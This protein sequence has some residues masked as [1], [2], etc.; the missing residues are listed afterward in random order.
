[1]N[2]RRFTPTPRIISRGPGSANCAEAAQGGQRSLRAIAAELAQ[3][4]IL[5]ERGRS[6]SAA[7]I[8]PMLV[9]GDPQ[10]H[11][12]CARQPA[13]RGRCSDAGDGAT[14]GHRYGGGIL[15]GRWVTLA[16]RNAARVR[17]AWAGGD[18]VSTRP[19]QRADCS[20]DRRNDLAGNA[21]PR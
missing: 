7:V 14:Q 20:K 1:M 4:G 21:K 5:N 17:R 13:D 2:S 12:I 15:C 9:P 3:R 10:S 8:N 6:Y 16:T 18:A 11:F 19:E